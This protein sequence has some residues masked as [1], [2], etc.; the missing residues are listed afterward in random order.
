ML[1]EAPRFPSFDPWTTS[2]SREDKWYVGSACLF[3]I[4]HCI[5]LLPKLRAPRH[6]D[7]LAE[8]RN[9]PSAAAGIS[10]RMGDDL[11]SREGVRPSSQS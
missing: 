6:C 11:C 8:R 5:V 3:V 9:R 10:V 1:N 4:L 2:R 7:A